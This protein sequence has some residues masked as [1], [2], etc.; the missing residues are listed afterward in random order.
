[1]L[2]DRERNILNIVS[3]LTEERSYPPTVREIGEAAG[4]KSTNGVRYFL[5]RL[6]AKGY[7]RRQEGKSRAIEMVHEPA[8]PA[9]RPQAPQGPQAVSVPLVGR[10]AAGYPLLSEENI[11]DNL[12]LDPSLAGPG[13]TFALRV[14]GDSMKDAGILDGDMVVVRE[15]REA[16]SGEIVVARVGDEATV[17]TYRSRRGGGVI[18]EPANPAFEPIVV[19]PEQSFEIAGKVVAVLRK[20]AGAGVG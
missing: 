9:W 19:G 3:R 15:Q 4:I 16:R 5:D 13:R 12:L 8:R 17:K 11:E 1:M 2:T 6:E 14:R 18:L 10:V 7:I 20:V